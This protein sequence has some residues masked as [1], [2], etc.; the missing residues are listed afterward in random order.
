[1]LRNIALLGK[2]G[3]GK[4]S[5]ADVLIRTHGYVPMS[6]ATPLKEMV[7]ECDPLIQCNCMSDLPFEREGFPVH[8]SDLLDSG[9]TFEECK[10]EYPEVR[11][12]LQRIGQG[13]RRHDPDYWLRSLFERALEIPASKNIVVTDVRYRNEADALRK[14][15]FTLIRVKRTTL[16]TGG[17][18]TENTRAMLHQS[19]VELDTYQVDRTIRNDGTKLDL[20]SAVLD[21]FA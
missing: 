7:V 9:K 8:L 4:D 16:N 5:V 2:M 3:S 12:V 6:F 21:L 10:R 19:E 11:R 1:M 17:Y 14:N 20:V 15:G 18:T 13:V